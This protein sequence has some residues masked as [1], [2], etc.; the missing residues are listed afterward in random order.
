MVGLEHGD[1]SGNVSSSD[2]FDVA[3]VAVSHDAPVVR[4]SSCARCIASGGLAP[5]MKGLF[6]CSGRGPLLWQSVPSITRL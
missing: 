2:L 1:Q 4:L 5:L 6:S 3:S